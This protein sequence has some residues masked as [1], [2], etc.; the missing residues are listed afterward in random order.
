MLTITSIWD[1]CLNTIR[2][3]VNSQSF[4]TWFSPIKPV[5]LEK[6]TLTL[7]VPSQF[8]YEWLEE[9]YIGVLCKSLRQELGE[10]AQLEYQIVVD[11][12]SN[13]KNATINVPTINGNNPLKNSEIKTTKDSKFENPF[14]IPG[15]K[16]QELDEKLLSKYS[17]ANFIEGECNRLA[18]SASLAVAENPGKTAF[19]PLLFYGG[20]GLG[21]THLAHAIGNQVRALFPEKRVVYVSS[22]KYGNQFIEA[23]KSNSLNNFNNFYQ[24]VDVL[25]VED[26]QFFRNKERTQDIF[27]HTFNNLHQAGKQIILTSDVPPKDLQGVEERLTSRFKWGLVADLQTPDFETRLAILERKLQEDG[28][29][30]Q[31]EIIDYVAHQ[32]KNNVREMEGALTSLI[33]ESTLTRKPLDM[34]LAKAIVQR[35]INDITEKVSIEGIQRMVSEYFSI[36]IDAIK[37]KTRKREVVQ[38]RHIGMYLA[39]EFTENSLRNIGLQFGGRDHSTVIH[40]CETVLNL[41]ATDID[42]KED[43]AELQKQLK[44]MDS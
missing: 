43:V 29:E 42:V 15:I 40:A 26:I 13:S 6:N 41:M 9:H 12:N 44:W 23:V 39:K 27:F 7:Q 4:Q 37:G 11:S 14:V 18:R 30:I 28:I 32:I 22:E 5:R 19:N 21:K 38:A 33:A 36:S 10:A 35:C 16:T 20:V 3:E 2:Q 25:I 17:F 1:N 24:Y 8:F 31:Q 34:H